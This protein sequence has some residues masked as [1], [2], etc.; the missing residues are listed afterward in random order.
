MTFEERLAV[1]I[2]TGRGA[3]VVGRWPLV[4]GLLHKVARGLKLRAGFG[5][6]RRLQIR[7]AAHDRGDAG[8]VVASGFGIVGQAGGHE[9]R[10]EIRVAQ[11]ERAVVVRVLADRF[12]GI[13]GVVHQN[14]L[15]GDHDVHGVAVGVDVERAVGRELHQVERRQVASGVVEKH[16][17]RAGIRGVDACRVLRRVPAVDGGIELHAGIAALPG[18]LG[19]FLQQVARLVSVDHAAA[20]DRTRREIGIALD[21]EHELIGHAHRV[22]GVLEEDGRI[23]FGVRRGAVVAGLHQRPGLGFFFGLAVDEV[24]DV[25]MVDVEDHHLGGAAG[26]ATRLDDAGEGVKAFHEAERSA[27]D[28]AAGKTFGRAAQRREIRAR[29]RSPLEQHAFGLGQGEDGIQRILHRIDEA[30]GALRVA[31]AAGGELDAA[32]FRVPV[33]VLG[34]GVGLDAVAADVEPHRR[35]ES[36]HLVQQDVHEFVVED[37]GVFGGAEVSAGEAP[38]LDGLGD[39]NDEL[40]HAGLALGRIH[41]AVEILAGHNVGGGHGPV[42]GDLHVFLL[43]DD[44]AGSVGDLRRALLPFDLVVG[45]DPGLSEESAEGKAGLAGRTG[46]GSGAGGQ[47]SDFVGNVSHVQSPGCLLPIRAVGGQTLFICTYMKPTP[48]RF[49]AEEAGGVTASKPPGSPLP[50]GSEPHNIPANGTCQ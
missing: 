36:G 39:A 10:A 46:V 20:E 47:A 18:G 5:N 15:R 33:P 31:I 13:A 19:D 42:L 3:A 27:G 43:E 14:L 12:G 50:T 22:V 17:F 2:E 6:P 34:V 35:I 4:V 30:G 8:G 24:D 32:D 9:Q 29:A 44:V 23:G 7:L 38:V 40:A 1:D 48:A 11:T 41:L 16:V 26:F 37:G 45:R 49:Q 25:G 21:R 28:A